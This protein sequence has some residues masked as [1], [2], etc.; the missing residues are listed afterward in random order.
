[1]EQGIRAFDAKVKRSRLDNHHPGFQPLFSKSAWKKDIRSRE[2]AL[3]RGNWFRGRVD[4]E[5]WEELP[6]PRA[7]GRTIRKMKK[8]FRKTGNAGM[9]RAAA[10][11]VFVPSTKGSLLLKSLREDEDRMEELTGFR[12]KYQ[13]A[14]GSVLSNA[15]NKNLGAGKKCG[16]KECPVCNQAEA[17]ADCKTRN[18]VYESKCKLCN[19]LPT[20]QKDMNTE[21]EEFQDAPAGR[22]PAPRE[23]IY[24][25]ESSRSI[26]ERAL[27]HVRDAR[28][29]SVKSH[30]VKHWMSSHPKLPTPPEM[31]FMV[32]GRFKDCLSRQISEALRINNSTDV[33]LNSKGE[34]EKQ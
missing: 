12:V 32:T 7:G 28:T 9:K 23:G 24:I 20:T 10:T 16:R 13:E 1:M 18:V 4:K 31:E 27:E 8:P 14:G 21:K 5:P 30:I 25:G 6:V 33:L 22:Q 11:V 15:F 3:K 29:F 26:H 17:G 19:P 34:Y 2:K